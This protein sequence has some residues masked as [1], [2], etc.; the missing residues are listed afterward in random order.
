MRHVT[1]NVPTRIHIGLADM[2]HATARAYGGVGF[3]IEPPCISWQLETGS[4]STEL[5]G[6]QHLDA[7]AII[8]LG[9]LSNRMQLRLNLPAFTATLL[10]CPAQHIG[11]GTKTALALGFAAAL[12]SLFSGDLTS[13]EL[14]KIV[15]RGGG[16]GIGINAFFTGGLVWDGGHAT[17][18]APTLLPSS[19]RPN[20]A[21]PPL[22]ARWEFPRTWRVVLLLPGIKETSNFDES[23]FFARICPVSKLESREALATL[24]H[25]VIPAFCLL[26]IDLLARS[27]RD[28]HAT[29]FK[30]RELAVQSKS[31][32]GLLCSL[33]E[34]GVAAGI[35]SLGPLIYAIVDE[36]DPHA[37]NRIRELAAQS[38]RM[39]M[40]PVMG[41][42]SGATIL[43][44]A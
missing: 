40:G 18:S 15:R 25:G 17:G 19:L 30:S 27:L 8:E 1:I 35:S 31:T 2:G 38:D 12:N 16:S 6:L 41:C 37:V 28:L 44:G 43:C 42:N 22:L 34:L 24:Y 14:Q 23:T 33:H 32:Q 20:V 11:F 7:R 9:E 13:F 5:K 29:G 10:S 3:S 4:D 26:D 21:V 39:F 36:A